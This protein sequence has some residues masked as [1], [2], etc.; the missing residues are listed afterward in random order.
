MFS[1]SYVVAR[2][3]MC[4]TVDGITAEI[5]T[6]NY[7]GFSG[8]MIMTLKVLD[9]YTYIGQIDVLFLISFIANSFALSRSRFI[10]V[11]L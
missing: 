11:I 4:F 8:V 2:G 10:P 3:L 5:T 1:S 6:L 9:S 7:G